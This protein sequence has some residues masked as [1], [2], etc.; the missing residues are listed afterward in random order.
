M[1]PSENIGKISLLSYFVSWADGTWC[2]LLLAG[3]LL[4][5]DNRSINLLMSW[6]EEKVQRREITVIKGIKHLHCKKRMARTLESPE[7][8]KAERWCVQA[9]QNQ[10]EVK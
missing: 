6:S 5:M 3:I 4:L 8:K 9:S 1:S 10:M 2:S 7:E